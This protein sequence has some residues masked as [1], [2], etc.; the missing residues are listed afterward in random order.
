MN[1]VLQSLTPSGD[2][3][4]PHAL[5]QLRFDALRLLGL[6]D[7][8]ELAAL[9]FCVTY[10]LSPP[11]WRDTVCRCVNVSTSLQEQVTV[12]DTASAFDTP[13]PALSLSGVVLGDVTSLVTQ[14]ES[15]SASEDPLVVSCAQLVRVDFS[16]AGGLL[17]WVATLTTEGRRVEFHE[18]P[19]LIAAFFNL[20]GINEHAR[21][22][23]RAH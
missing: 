8:Y 22:L 14:W 5:W 19:R 17:N 15:S 20:I 11:P 13:S 10:E 1:Q 21:V 12:Q 7:D 9:D 16:A 3:T 18:V 2:K 4:I 6:Q 23:T